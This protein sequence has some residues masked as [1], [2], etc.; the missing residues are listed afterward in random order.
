LFLYSLAGFTSP[1]ETILKSENI[2]LKDNLGTLGKEMEEVNGMLLSLQDRDVKIYRMITGAEEL[3]ESMRN[4]GIGGSTHY[5]DIL[6][7]G[8][9]CQHLIDEN[10]ENLAEIKRKMYGQTLSYDEIILT[11]RKKEEMLA[12]IP[13]IQPVSNK[14]LK[15]LASGYGLRIHPIYKVKKMHWGCD[16]SAPKGSPIYATGDGKIEYTKSTYGG[17]GKQIQIDHGFGY[18]S[19]YAH[20]QKMVV[21]RGQKVKRGELIGYVGNTG[22]STAPHLHYEIIHNG[23]KV[24]PVHYFFNDLNSDQYEQILKLAS[25]ENQ[26]FS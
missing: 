3:P 24:N 23:K 13:A 11:A 5:Q 8:N 1:Q 17:Y 20:L 2:A 6:H 16:F 15:R 22:S 25:V 14:Q 26:S 19:K 4:P 9:D 7:D 12:S 21:K 18:K 10:Q